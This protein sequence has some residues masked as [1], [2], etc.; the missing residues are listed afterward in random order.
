MG[1]MNTVPFRL[2]IVSFTVLALVFTD[3]LRLGFRTAASPLPLNPH[4]SPI[5]QSALTSLVG[6]DEPLRVPQ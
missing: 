4:P 2:A 1:K 5:D 6:S 3:I